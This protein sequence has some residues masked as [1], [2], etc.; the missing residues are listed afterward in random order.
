MTDPQEKTDPTTGAKTT[1][2]G[3]SRTYANRM[4]GRIKYIFRWAASEELVPGTVAEAL[5]QVDAVRK[6]RDGVRETEKVMPVNPATVE[7][8]LPHLPPP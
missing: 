5:A 1:V 2:A 3:W 8:T 6:G 7:A 4:T